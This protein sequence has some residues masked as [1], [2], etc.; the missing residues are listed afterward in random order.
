MDAQEFAKCIYREL[1]DPSGQCY[2]T[3]TDDMRSVTID[4]GYDLVEI[5]ENL[6]RQI[7]KS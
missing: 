6:L 4:G 7:A 1:Q 2:V 3:A 5:A